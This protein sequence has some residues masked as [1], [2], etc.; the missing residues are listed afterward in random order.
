MA[1]A[2]ET[3]HVAAGGTRGS[4][5][6]ATNAT[7]SITPSATSPPPTPRANRPGERAAKPIPPPSAAQAAVHV[8]S[9][10]SGRVFIGETAPSP[11]RTSWLAMWACNAMP[12]VCSAST[13]LRL[14]GV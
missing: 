4:H 12:D 2:A 13:K 6:P 3:S 9:C 14:Y 11:I 1:T 10:Q 8:A 7:K 5:H